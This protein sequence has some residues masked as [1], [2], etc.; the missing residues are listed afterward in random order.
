MCTWSYVSDNNNNHHN[1]T[2]SC[3]VSGSVFDLFLNW[4]NDYQQTGYGGM[5]ENPDC[6]RYQNGMRTHSYSP[7]GVIKAVYGRLFGEMNPWW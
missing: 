1:K 5:T 6:G 4:S 3:I 2:F 7:H